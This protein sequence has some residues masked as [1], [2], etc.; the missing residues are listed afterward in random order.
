MHFFLRPS[1]NR[2]TTITAARRQIPSTG[3]QLWSWK[4]TVLEEMGCWTIVKLTSI[5]RDANWVYKLKYRN[6]KYE[7]HKAR[8]VTLGY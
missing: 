4:L 2:P 1:L 3:S 8:F 6:G 5:P 7:R